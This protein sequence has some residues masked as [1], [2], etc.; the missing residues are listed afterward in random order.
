MQKGRCKHCHRQGL[1]ITC[2]QGLDP[3]AMAKAACRPGENYRAGLGLRVPCDSAAFDIELL[4][5]GGKP[6][7]QQLDCIGQKATCGQFTEPSAEEIAAYEADL[8]A[9]SKNMEK[10]SSLVVRIKAAHAESWQ[11]IETCPACSGKLHIKLN[12]FFSK[13]QGEDQK[14]CHGRCETPGC[15]QWAE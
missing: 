2:D 14:H 13:M 15:L 1:K 7:Q 4:S 3:E 10:V 5:R 11:G 6:S 12:V 8:D 9:F